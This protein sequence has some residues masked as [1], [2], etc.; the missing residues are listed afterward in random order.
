MRNSV[1]LLAL[2]SAFSCGIALEDTIAPAD[3][4]RKDWKH[5]TDEDK[6]CQ[7]ARQEVL[8]EESST[9]VVFEDEKR[10]RVESGTWV[11][12][13]TGDTFTDPGLLDVDHVVALKDAYL[14]GS[15]LWGA[16]RRE[17]FAND[18]T[19]S[20]SLRAVYLG[21]NR[22]KGSRGPDEWLPP[23]PNFRCQYIEEYLGIKQV[24]ELKSSERQKAVL[25]YMLK[26]CSD[27]GA[28]PL[29]Q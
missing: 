20:Q 10:C 17:L 3:Y 22:S 28:P 6:D 24:W 8:I 12:P 14:S 25:E 29:P 11:D 4:S 2:A 7:D 9:A 13:Y 16:F 5:W 27:G 21:A 18:L 23:N 1:L 19:N 26:I 15:Y